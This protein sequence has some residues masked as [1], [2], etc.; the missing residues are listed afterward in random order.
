MTK[1]LKLLNVVIDV[2]VYLM[3]LTFTSTQYNINL[4]INLKEKFL[5]V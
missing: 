5:A 1:Y 3:D 4:L 2:T